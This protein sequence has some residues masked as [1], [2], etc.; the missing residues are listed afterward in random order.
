MLDS[1]VLF[2][3][4]SLREGQ[5]S[6]IDEVL[7]AIKTKTNLMV[8][9]PTGIGKT[10][11]VLA[12]AL[13]YAI[14]NNLTIFFL[15]SRHTQHKI[16]IETLK[17]IKKI[18]NE[19]FL[20]ADFIGKKNMC[21]V[22]G[23]T[24]FSTRDFYDY[25]ND[26]VEKN[27]CNFF[28]NSKSKKLKY[29]RESLI[30]EISKINPL[31]V[32]EIVN[33]SKN[34]SFCGFEISC[35]IAKNA[36][37][38]IADY[39]HV[40]NEGIRDALFSKINKTLEK[41]IIIFD[42]SHNLPD[43][44]RDLMTENL[45]S[46]TIDYAL[47]EAEKFDFLE[48]VEF[49]ELLNNIYA[50]IAKEKLLLDEDEVIVTKDDI[51]SR[52]SKKIDYFKLINDLEHLSE[53]VREKQRRS[54][55]GSLANFLKAWINQDEGFIRIMKRGYFVNKKP[56]TLVS[57]RCLDP[58][59]VIDPILKKAHSSIFMSGTLRP[60]S[61]YKDLLGISNTTVKEYKNPFPESN[62][63]NIIVNSVT[64]KFTKR[65]ELMYQKIADKC[66]KIM[67]SVPGN[68]II[69]FPSYDLLNK[70]SYFIRSNKKIYYEKPNAT[71]EEKMD[72]LNEF[73]LSFLVGASLM[74]V[75]SGSYG[76]G[77]DLPGNLLK[78][79]V[80]VGLPLAKPDLETKQ[81]VNYYD[82]KF[83]KGMEYGYLFPA[84]IRCIQNAGRCI[85]SENDK[86]VV[87][88]LEERFALPYY[89]NLM[90]E[91]FNYVITNNPELE[92]DNFFK[93]N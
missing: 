78:C 55:I 84:L 11:A 42:E 16:V 63:L 79:V 4:K 68:S 18:H 45:S 27:L 36:N 70:V 91:T 75:S 72:L 25:C 12:P 39:F 57:Y 5:D 73:K 24:D 50:E 64:T 35:D 8:H 30:D 77:I 14:D 58:S 66:S 74:A 2:P 9:A 15:T 46:N 82:K 62:R 92:I 13:R 32:E 3:Y 41:S 67:D 56:Y 51:I 48:H 23:I 37:V 52:I 22:E 49:I 65:S 43:R 71:N 28:D 33:L 34:R 89:K 21:S 17:E 87:V 86:G 59:I 19:K 93:K 85:R 81:L 7:N 6:F 53:Q 60:T 38:I 44:C 47:R 83:G 31:H 40:L 90:P 1:K 80:V 76:E 61:M 10:V 69:F 29:E 54:F 88:F 20:V 26:V